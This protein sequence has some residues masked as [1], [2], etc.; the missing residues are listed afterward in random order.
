MALS[1]LEKRKHEKVSGKTNSMLVR[2]PTLS[3]N[4]VKPPQTFLK[5]CCSESVE[6]DR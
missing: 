2:A 4:P 3:K 1:D 5:K 6:K